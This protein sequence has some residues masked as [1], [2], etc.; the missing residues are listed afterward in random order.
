ML[1]L[2]SLAFAQGSENIVSAIVNA[3]IALIVGLVILGLLLMKFGVKSSGGQKK[4]WVKVLMVFH[5]VVGVAVAY[6]LQLFIWRLAPPD[7][8]QRI[9]TDAIHLIFSPTS[10][11]IATFVIW[12]VGG[13]LLFRKFS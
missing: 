5:P 13:Y 6:G 4:A 9:G 3:F 1:L 10:W 12:L 8:S 11:E 2:C 7:P